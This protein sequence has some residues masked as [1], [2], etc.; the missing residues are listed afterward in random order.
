MR[1]GGSDHQ[2]ALVT[3]GGSGI[4][5]ALAKLLA[6]RG[7]RVVVT[8]VDEGRATAIAE[9][10]GGR[11]QLLDVTDAAAFEAVVDEIYETEG[12]L[13]DLFNNAGVGL[14]GLVVDLTT[15][16]WRSVVEVN[17]WGVVNGIHA[18]YPRMV[19]A[20]R[21]AIV[22]TAS[23]AGLCPRPGMTPYATTK[24]AVVGLTT[25]LRPEAALHGVQVNTFCPG[26]IA[27]DI[28]RATRFV[29]VDGEG[30]MEKV[31][32]RPMTA[33][34]CAQI[35]LRGVDRNRAV[36]PVSFYVWLDWL[37]FRL[38]PRLSVWIAGF[39]AR[40]FAAHRKGAEAS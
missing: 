39:R 2:V 36:I 18:V 3:G 1:S 8:D 13:D 37:I 31:P 22:N 29:G 7:V 16:D 40:Q 17:L 21:G 25:S 26:Y 24:H 10:V 38:S 11:A 12:R 14:A 34:R 23:G 6:A 19:A 27:T 20:G 30:M 15:E 35:A 33:E 5:A 32:I 28:V 4:G 9:A